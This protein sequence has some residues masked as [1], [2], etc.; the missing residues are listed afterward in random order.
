MQHLGGGLQQLQGGLPGGLQQLQGGLPGGLQGTSAIRWI[1]G[2]KTLAQ[3]RTA[4]DNCSLCKVP[5]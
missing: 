3:Q 1:L 2:L 4:Q 5:T